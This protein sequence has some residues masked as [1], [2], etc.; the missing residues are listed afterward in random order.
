MRHVF[1]QAN[2]AHEDE[3]RDFALDGAGGL[4]HDSVFRPGAGGDFVF[5]LREAKEDDGGNAQREQ[6]RRASFT[7]SS[8]ERLNTPGMERTSF[9]TP[10]PGQTNRG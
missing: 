10:S 1:A 8:T 5:G 6:V 4:L 2:I 7:A 3:I 9:R